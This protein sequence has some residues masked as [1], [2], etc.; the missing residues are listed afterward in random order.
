MPADEG[1][2]VGVGLGLD[3]VLKDKNC[4]IALYFA[5]Q[6]L[7]QLPPV[8]RGEVLFGQEGRDP[9]LADGAS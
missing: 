6:R 5:C 2:L 3:A 8:G 4:H 7:N 1:A 9:V